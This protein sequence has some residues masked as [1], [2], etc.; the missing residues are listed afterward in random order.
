[1]NNEIEA[2]DIAYIGVDW[3]DKNDLPSTPTGVFVTVTSKRPAALIRAETSVG[4][5]GPTM[6]IVITSIENGMVDSNSVTEIR[7]VHL[8]A[9]FGAGD[10]FNKH[11]EYRVRKS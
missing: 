3:R 9:V 8:R 6:E 7:H 1:M 10:E 4:G 2:G 5:L 11:Y